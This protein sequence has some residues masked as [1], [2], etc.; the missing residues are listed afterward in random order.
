M[1]VWCARCVYERNGLPWRQVTNRAIVWVKGTSFCEEHL[2]M[3]GTNILITAGI[4]DPPA[5]V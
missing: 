1:R 2:R 3:Q 4:I 5:T